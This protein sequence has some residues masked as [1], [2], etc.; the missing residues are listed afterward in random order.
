MTLH[1]LGPFD[2]WGQIRLHFL[3]THDL[4]ANASPPDDDPREHSD[5]KRP[6]VRDESFYWRFCMSGHW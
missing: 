3:R 2:F 5:T 6:P 1:E 4:A